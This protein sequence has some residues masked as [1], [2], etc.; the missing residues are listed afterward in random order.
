MSDAVVRVLPDVPAIDR[1]FD[2]VVADTIDPPLVVGSM[3]RIPLSGRRVAGWVLETQIDPMAGVDLSAIDKVVGHGPAPG[4]V[5]LCRWAAWRWSGRL[6]TMLRLASPERSVARVPPLRVRAA[7]ATNG[8]SPGI[9][10]LDRGP[11]CHVVEVSPITDGL[12]IA[13]AAAG[14]GQ[15]IVVVPSVQGADRIARGLRGSGAAVARW[16]S[17]FAAALG[18]ASVVGGRSAV[19]APAPALAAIVVL[20]EHDEMLQS[21]ASPSWHA[22]EVAVERARREGVPCLLVSPC[23][24]LE[25]L[26]AQQPGAGAGLWTPAAPAVAADGDA[27]DGREDTPELPAPC[28]RLATT[29]RRAG[30]APLT[31]I[32]RR[33]EDS[34][35]TGLYSERLVATVREVARAGGR[36]V[37]VLNR[38]GRARL[39]ACRSCG[40]LAECERCGAAVHADDQ[41]DLVCSRCGAVRPGVCMECGSTAMATLRVGVTRAREE[42][43]VLARE[44]VL[45]VTGRS[46]GSGGAGG[47]AGM[48]EQERSSA[49]ARIVIGTEA[50]LHRVVDADL[51]AFLDLDQELMAPRYRAAEEA[52][53]LVVRANRLLGGRTRNGRLVVQTRMPEHEVVQAAVRADP[54]LV[55]LVEAERRRALRFPPAATIAVVGGAAAEEYVERIRAA[56]PLSAAGVSVAGPVEG[57]YIVRSDDSELLLDLLAGIRRPPGRL[58]L[59]VDPARVR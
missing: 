20:D 50:V 44:P 35:R 29:A 23:P 59:Q 12:A 37:C 22:R 32:D 40:T 36:V 6:A 51:V 24:S 2:Y 30:W 14:R 7:R 42:L 15:V 48:S 46:G 1:A 53:A 47:A 49:G 33:G 9:E 34:G 16:P 58:S 41:F 21:E 28:E 27:A 31:V 54:R 57:R 18:G 56:A 52:L 55:T 11:G 45:A 38:T 17:D 25:A 10:A 43:E 3:V 8:H 26:G 19:F 5:D 4:Q 13:M 39:L